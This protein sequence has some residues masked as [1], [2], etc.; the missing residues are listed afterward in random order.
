MLMESSIKN[1]AQEIVALA[2]R[3]IATNGALWYTTYGDRDNESSIAHLLGV[4][5]TTLL[6]IYH[7]CGWSHAYS[8]S[9]NQPQFLQKD[10]ISSAQPTTLR[11]NLTSSIENSISESDPS[12]KHKASSLA[13]CKQSKALSNQQSAQP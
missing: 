9:N 13:R 7:L 6:K 3:L 10:L 11:L 1:R 4:D 5:Y 12:A 8:S 2:L